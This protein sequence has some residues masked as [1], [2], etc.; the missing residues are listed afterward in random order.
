ML[1]ISAL[2]T[3][4]GCGGKDTPK[5]TVSDTTVSTVTDEKKEEP[6]KIEAEPVAIGNKITLEFAEMT[7]EEA[8][9]ANDIKISIK[10]GNFTHTTG[11]SESEDTEFVYIRGKIKNTTTTSIDNA[12]IIGNV[13]FGE[14]TYDIKN[15]E[16]IESDG[17]YANQMD[18]LV[19]Y[20]YTLY[21]EVPNALLETA[22]SGTMNFAFNEKFDYQNASK[23]DMANMPYHY[24]IQIG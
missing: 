1:A 19:E 23:D 9:I 2:F 5:S 16:M 20:T 24:T 7:I 12:E 15:F 8:A 18:P 21:A 10:K 17:S 14:Y 11:P 22:P 13:Q 6:K 3:V 4:A